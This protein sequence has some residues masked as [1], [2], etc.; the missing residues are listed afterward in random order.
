MKSARINAKEREKVRRAK[1]RK[2][3]EAQRVMPSTPSQANDMHIGDEEQ[4]GKQKKEKKI[5][6]SRSEEK[7]VGFS[8]AS[9]FLTR[10]W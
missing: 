6:E 2:G 5:C 4:N 10:K 1:K 9:L 8:S 7:L 3:I